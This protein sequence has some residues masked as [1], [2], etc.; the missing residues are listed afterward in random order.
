MSLVDMRAGDLTADQLLH[1]ASI[2]RALENADPLPPL[3]YERRE[4]TTEERCFAFAQWARELGIDD[5][6]IGSDLYRKLLAYDYG[7]EEALEVL[8][9]IGVNWKPMTEEEQL[10]RIASEML[11]AGWPESQVRWALNSLVKS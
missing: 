7:S 4:R 11:A 6:M 9:N 3:E 1:L 5:A 8:R 10:V 2:K